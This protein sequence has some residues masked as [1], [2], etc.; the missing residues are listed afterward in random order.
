MRIATRSAEYKARNEPGEAPRAVLQMLRGAYFQARE[1]S[2]IGLLVIAVMEAVAAGA[3]AAAG[4]TNSANCETSPPEARREA[5][6]RR[7]DLRL[8][9][10]R[11]RH[12]QRPDDHW[13]RVA[14][15]RPRRSRR[16]YPQRQPPAAA[17]PRPSLDRRR[18]DGLCLTRQANPN[19][20]VE[21]NILG[22]RAHRPRVV[23]RRAPLGA[24]RLCR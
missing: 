3:E 22:S 5:S 4:N 6:H 9:H 20:S 11:Q 24:D 14:A 12:S 2:G 8:E 1:R 19:Q 16:Q 15:V 13:H 10:R 18:L 17:A 7:P 23:F 21:I